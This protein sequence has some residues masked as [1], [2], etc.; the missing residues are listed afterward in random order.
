MEMVTKILFFDLIGC[1]HC[2]KVRE[3]IIPRAKVMIENDENLRDRVE[4]I[5]YV[6]DRYT[7]RYNIPL[8]PSMEGI[9]V[10]NFPSLVVLSPGQESSDY[11]ITDDNLCP[12]RTVSNGVIRHTSQDNHQKSPDIEEWII[13]ILNRIS[14]GDT[15]IMLVKPNSWTDWLLSVISRMGRWMGLSR[16]I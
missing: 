4:I 7:G 11:T 1:P 3:S 6:V 12:S 2:V 15:E 16:Y 14:R 8:S 10:R 9:A 13:E 5:T